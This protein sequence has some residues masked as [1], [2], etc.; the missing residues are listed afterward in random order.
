MGITTAPNPENQRIMRA[1]V[2]LS[3]VYF[4]LVCGNY[5][6]GYWLPTIV[7]GVATTLKLDASAGI[8]INTL[9]GYLVAIPYP[10]ALS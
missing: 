3:L 10:I 8:N 5:G 1:V 2:A 9:T 4:G 7:K 6:L